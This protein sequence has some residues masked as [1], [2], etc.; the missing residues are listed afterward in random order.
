MEDRWGVI[1]LESSGL[2]WAEVTE[3][4]AK[5]WAEVASW[6]WIYT[7]YFGPEFFTPLRNLGLEFPS[8]FSGDYGRD[9]AQMFQAVR[10]AEY[11]DP[12]RI[13]DGVV[14]PKVSGWYRV[15]LHESLT[16]T[17]VLFVGLDMASS[18]PEGFSPPYALG[19]GTRTPITLDKVKYWGDQLPTP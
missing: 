18:A 11:A 7:N 4:K 16:A 9:V 10:D 8:S 17:Y 14:C 13:P 1:G 5:E 19:V 3:E 2:P 12:H 6:E 15:I